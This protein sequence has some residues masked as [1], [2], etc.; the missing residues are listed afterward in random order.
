MNPAD[1]YYAYQE[2][3]RIAPTLS[4]LEYMRRDQELYRALKKIIG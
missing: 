4:H 3:Y 2:L 1:I